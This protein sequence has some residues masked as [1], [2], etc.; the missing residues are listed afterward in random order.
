MTFPLP[1][2]IDSTD[3][4]GIGEDDHE[5]HHDSVHRYINM[6]NATWV[7]STD[8]AVTL[9]AKIDAGPV[10]LMED[11]SID[12]SIDLDRD[13]IS[14][15]LNGHTLIYTGTG[16]V[17]YLNGNNGR[18]GNGIINP[19]GSQNVFSVASATSASGWRFHDLS[20]STAGSCVVVVGTLL[21]SLFESFEFTAEAT[22]VPVVDITNATAFKENVFHRGRFFQPAS[23]TVPIVRISCVAGAVNNNEWSNCRLDTSGSPTSPCILVECTSA[24]WHYGNV[25]K[26][27]N[28]SAP[29]QGAIA[30]YSCFG[31]VINEVRISDVITALGHL[32]YIGK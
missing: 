18:I 8:D 15:E 7:D 29:T 6:A 30:L 32:I 25:F 11:V 5:A 10:I 14:I 16:S 13:D 28:F 20:V 17:F 23:S 12:T 4:A 3:H 26:H 27:L 22:G 2:N 9:Q 19:S 1:T 24:G 31:S 21:R